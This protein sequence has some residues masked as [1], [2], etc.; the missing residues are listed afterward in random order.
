[1]SERS[2]GGRET[3]SLEEGK[4]RYNSEIAKLEKEREN[5]TCHLFLFRWDAFFLFPTDRLV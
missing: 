1:M 5:L 2:E 3:E 4:G